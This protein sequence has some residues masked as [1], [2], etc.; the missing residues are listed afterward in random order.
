MLSSV[1]AV[2]FRTLKD[3][4]LSLAPMTAIV[5]PNGAGK[6]ALLDAV[7]FIL[8]SR[9]PSMAGLS[10][11]HDFHRFDVAN[12]LC[13]SV[14]FDPPL[15]H[16]DALNTDHAIAAI[17]YEC[18]PYK[19]AGRWGDAGDL[20]DVL[21]PLGPDGSVPSVAVSRPARNSPPQFRPLSVTNSL[22]D[23]ARVLVI[24]ERREIASH[25]PSRRGSALAL[26]LEGA[27]KE[28]AKDEGGSKSDFA[29][30]YEAAMESLKTERVR[31]IEQL[32]GSTAKRMLGFMGSSSVDSLSIRFGFADPSNPF[33]SLRLVCDDGGLELPADLMGR[34]IQSALVVGVF[35]ALRTLGGPVGT[36]LIEEPEA[37]LHP[38]AQRYFYALL[39]DLVDDQGCQVV[40]TTHSPI[41]ADMRRFEGIR[42]LR[43]V[44]GES[45][46]SWI[47]ADEDRAYLDGQRSQEKLQQYMDAAT[48]ELLFAKRVLLVEGHGDKIAVETAA[49][50]LPV[51]LDA[52]DF[53]VVACGGK[54]RI[55]FF[56]RAC[57]ALNIPFAVLHDEDLYEGSELAQ[58]QEDE[59]KRAP[60]A[61]DRIREAAGDGTIIHLARPTLEE[62]LGIGRNASDKPRRILEQIEGRKLD[63]LPECLA[64]AVRTLQGLEPALANQESPPL[65]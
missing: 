36:I 64:R 24:D 5:G 27:R 23:Q 45:M 12:D 2:N 35:D 8:G 15:T 47:A 60:G 17:R 42:L 10:V 30:Q 48:S 44:G 29:Q 58:W 52:E 7:G 54:E 56:A 37:Y 19:R 16:T 6:S 26:L 28:F 39:R 50:S 65:T 63:Q 59:N 22:R 41:F 43:R 9:W 62:E 46:T 20:H 11:P 4:S 61:N 53:S 1:D 34:G 14:S 3:V 49:Q 33:S 31:E 13:I 55:P 38:Q 21:S 57:R 18:K 51:D 25:L 40:Y 32:V